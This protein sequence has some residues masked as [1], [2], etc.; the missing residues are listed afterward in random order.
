MGKNIS[1]LLAGLIFG[2]GLVISQMV[3]PAKVLSFLDVAGDWDPSLAFVMVG[4]LAVTAIGYSF[5]FRRPKPAFDGQFHVPTNR[6]IDMKLAVGAVMFGAGW[7]LVGLCPGPA[8][9][10]LAIGGPQAFE[11][12]AA[13]LGGVF[14]YQLIFV[15]K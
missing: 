11:F 8:I 10:S 13:M 2:L 6:K 14:V 9:A 15:R 7:G 12:V 5:V 3:N 4:G 1:A